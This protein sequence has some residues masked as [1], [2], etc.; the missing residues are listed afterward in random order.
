MTQLQSKLV[1]LRESM[2]F[3]DPITNETVSEM[4]KFVTD[5][6][7]AETKLNQVHNQM[8]LLHMLHFN[9]LDHDAFKKLQAFKEKTEKSLDALL[10]PYNFSTLTAILPL[11]TRIKIITPR[12]Y[13]QFEQ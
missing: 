6:N 13:Q 2:Q 11:N 4:I 1:S 8:E 7:K 9:W 12:L 10:D 5:L 3:D